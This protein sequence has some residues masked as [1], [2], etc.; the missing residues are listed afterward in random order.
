MKKHIIILILLA[1]GINSFSQE[2]VISENVSEYD[3][4]E[5]PKYGINGKNYIWFFMDM[6]FYTPNPIDDQAKIQ[7]GR[8]NAF[9]LGLKYKHRIF[10]WFGTGLKVA[11]STQK[12]RYTNTRI[13]NFTFDTLISNPASTKYILNSFE[14]EY[15]LRFNFGKYGSSLGKYLDLGVFGGYVAN[16]KEVIKIKH[17]N[18]NKLVKEQ[19]L[20]NKNL[21]FIEN[22]QYGGVARIGIKK[23][24]IVA[25]YR[26]SDIIEKQTLNQYKTY[27]L[28]KL[29]VGIELNLY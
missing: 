21:S 3:Y 16:T 11:F 27:D 18:S 29:S 9:T 4:F 28:P 25:K 23:L 2:Y 19:E 5:M 6:S 24:A 7:Y 15:Y 12:F 10:N 8:S 17:K 20:F 13:N 22:L 26:L 1:I 14:G